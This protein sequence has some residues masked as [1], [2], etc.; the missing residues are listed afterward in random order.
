MFPWVNGF[1]WDAGHLIFLS[2]FFSVIA[3]VLST[4]AIA[5]TRARSDFQKRKVDHIRW[6]SDFEELPLIARRCRH[7]FTGELKQRICDHE[8]ECGSCPVKNE[9][10]ELTAHRGVG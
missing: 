1:S 6:K 4:V 5:M 7:D 9:C 8:F 2:L 10:C 3:V